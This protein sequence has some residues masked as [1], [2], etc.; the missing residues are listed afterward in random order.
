M[1]E[2]PVHSEE[3]TH[4]C[5]H[6]GDSIGFHQS[7]RLLVGWTPAQV[8]MW[9]CRAPQEISERESRT[10]SLLWE[11]VVQ[12]TADSQGCTLFLTLSFLRIDPT[13]IGTQIIKHVFSCESF[14]AWVHSVRDWKQHK[15]LWEGM[16]SMISGPMDKWR[17]CSSQRWCWISNC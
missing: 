13:K 8:T 6:Y 16:G 9:G 12:D 5:K 15:C 1:L 4:K 14:T 10:I 2:M 7:G 11:N 3:D 17:L